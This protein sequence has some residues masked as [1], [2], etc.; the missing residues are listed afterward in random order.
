VIFK[1]SVVIYSETKKPSKMKSLFDDAL[2]PS[3]AYYYL[4]DFNDKTNKKFILEVAPE[5]N[6]RLCLV[7]KEEFWKLFKIATEF[8]IKGDWSEFE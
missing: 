2:V 1:I 4:L 8:E 6:G 7:E 3:R 5:S